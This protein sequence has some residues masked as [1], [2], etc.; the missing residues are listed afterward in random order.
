E[1][2]IGL[3]CA[4]ADLQTP[5]IPGLAFGLAA[6][7]L[8]QTASELSP[9]ITQRQNEASAQLDPAQLEQDML[10]GPRYTASDLASL[11]QTVTGF[12]PMQ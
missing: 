2:L 4:A 12:P 5:T 3:G 7:L 6:H 11:V 10:A 8:E 1:A 9:Y